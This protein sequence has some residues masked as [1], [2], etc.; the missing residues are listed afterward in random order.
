MRVNYISDNQENFLIIEEKEKKDRIL[1]N[2][3]IDNGRAVENRTI[4]YASTIKYRFHSSQLKLQV[5]V[6]FSQGL[7][8]LQ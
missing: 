4:T 5:V 7:I 8:D 1:K 6:D 2:K 3:T